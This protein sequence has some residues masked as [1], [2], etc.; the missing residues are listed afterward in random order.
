MK[1]NG[2]T[3]KMSDYNH[4]SRSRKGSTKPKMGKCLSRKL[5]CLCY[6]I[7]CLNRPDGVGCLKCE[8]ACFEHKNIEGRPY[9]DNNEDCTCP[10]CLCQCSVVYH[11]NEEK[12]LAA[13]AKFE[14]M[15]S[16]N[17]KPQSRIDGFFGFTNAIANL[18]KNRLKDDATISS[19][20]L[21]GLTSEDT[22]HLIELQQDVDLRNTLQQSVEAIRS[23]EL[24][25][26]NGVPKSLA[27]LRREARLK[28]FSSPHKTLLYLPLKNDSVSVVTPVKCVGVNTNNCWYSHQHT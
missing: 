20:T 19:S 18:A 5:A 2:F 27:Q 12:K 17:T 22:L 21:L 3:E 13:Q 28:I 23:Y 9:F 25:D 8:W 16:L 6:R 14:I 7:H 26:G 10:I 11:R 15:E 4:R 24:K 1:S